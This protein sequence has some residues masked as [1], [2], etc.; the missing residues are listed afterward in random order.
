MQLA[1]RAMKSGCRCS[2]VRDCFAPLAMTGL[3]AKHTEALNALQ[4]GL[5][6]ILVGLTHDP[7]FYGVLSFAFGNQVDAVF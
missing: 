4:S 5:G 3:R 2:F 7:I 6:T 1:M